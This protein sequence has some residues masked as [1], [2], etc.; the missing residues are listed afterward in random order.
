[1]GGQAV[2]DLVLYVHLDDGQT[3]T[4]GLD[5]AG[6][7]VLSANVPTPE[8]SNE[9]LRGIHINAE[10][11]GNASSVTVEIVARHVVPGNSPGALG[12]DGDRIGFAL[13]VMGVE[14]APPGPQDFDED[15][16]LDPQDACASEP[17]GA[18]DLDG[19]G[20]PDDRDM[21]GIND[22]DDACPDEDARPA[23]VN[24]DGC[25]D[26]SDTDGVADHL[27]ACPATTVDPAWPTRADGCR[28]ADAVPVVEASFPQPNHAPDDALEVVVM[29]FDAD[30]DGGTLL[31]SLVVDGVPLPGSQVQANGTGH[32]RLVWNASV[33]AAPW[34]EN[35]S[36]VDVILTFETSNASPEAT[37]EV[38]MPAGQVR[39]VV[40]DPPPS[41]SDED[42]SSSFRPIVLAGLLFLLLV[43]L[44]RWREPPERDPAGPRDPF[45]ASSRPREAE[46]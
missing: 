44:I 18:I 11:L 42:R 27:D 46:Q 26:D 22:E 12:A 39:T 14:R 10:D 38:A 24:D 25:L 2:D 36:L 13:A 1:L 4:S 40:L 8:R 15:G 5:F 37:M 31:A 34:I 3:A 19:D 45:V 23:D 29:V 21:D 6:A 20:C 28:P 35:G 17:A 9:T 7:S 16:V 43:A 41:T 32:H 33:W 30:D